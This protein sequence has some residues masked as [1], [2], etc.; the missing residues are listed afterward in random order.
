[1]LLALGGCVVLTS[2][3][4]LLGSNEAQPS[5]MGIALLLGAAFIM[6]LLARKKRELAGIG[7]FYDFTPYNFS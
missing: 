7:N 5:F 6:P 3:L 4:S 2:T 1:L